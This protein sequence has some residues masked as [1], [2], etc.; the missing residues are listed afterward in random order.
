MG[1]LLTISN[2][3]LLTVVVNFKEFFHINVGGS[4]VKT[5]TP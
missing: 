1:R 2:E 3:N 5:L 4:K